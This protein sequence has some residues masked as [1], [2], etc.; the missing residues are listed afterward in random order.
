MDKRGF[1]KTLEAVLAVMIVFIFIFTMSSRVSNEDSKQ[2]EMK[3][4][5]EGLLMGV[6]QNNDY[7]NCIISTNS[8]QLSQISTGNTCPEI[9]N[10]VETTLPNRFVKNERFEISV[11]DP[12][13]GQDDPG[14]CDVSPSNGGDF[15][16]TSAVIISSDSNNY[17]PRIFR[18]WMW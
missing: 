6:S 15:I 9:K 14:N 2:G 1:I 4:I 16:Y 7:R 17:N 5:Q 13:L 12:T 8:A 3:G 11:C 18:I 10:Y